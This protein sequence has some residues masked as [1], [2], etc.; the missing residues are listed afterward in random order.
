[1]SIKVQVNS[2]IVPFSRGILTRSI[3]K[4]GLSTGEA[5]EIAEIVKKDLANKE[6]KEVSK[7]E[8]ENLTYK[9]LLNRNEEEIAKKYKIINNINRM[10]KALVLM[11]GGST[12]VG[13]ST[14]AQELGYRLDIPNLI[15]TDTIRELMRHMISKDLL[16][17]LHMS[18]FEAWKPLLGNIGSDKVIQGYDRQVSYVSVGMKAMISRAKTEGT[19]M[20]I[21]GIH[22]LPGY[23]FTKTD[24][25]I[26][27]EY[28]LKLTDKEDHKERFITRAS[29]SKRPAKRYIKNMDIVEK[30]QDFIID[31]AKE[32]NV[33]VIENRNLEQTID[34][35]L[36]DIYKKLSDEVENNE[37]RKI[38]E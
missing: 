25:Q 34:I 3:Q 35:I 22:V 4:A 10:D 26:V 37:F 15:G 1:M 24:D 13:K 28:V 30:I 19:N 5:H 11:I 27:L 18:T 38:K 17:S 14:I 12:G 21:N 7:R 8:I 36:E 23:K 9:E 6:V 31:K 33:K 16:P 29:G 32:N 2:D 20:I